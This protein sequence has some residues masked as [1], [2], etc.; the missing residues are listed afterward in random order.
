[1]DCCCEKITGS[2]S[3]FCKETVTAFCFCRAVSTMFMPRYVSIII[4]KHKVF[5]ILAQIRVG[6]NEF[7]WI[8]SN[9]CVEHAG[10]ELLV[11][12]TRDVEPMLGWRWPIVYDAGLTSTQHWFNVSCLASENFLSK[13]RLQ[14]RDLVFWT[15]ITPTQEQFFFLLGNFPCGKKLDWRNIKRTCNR[16]DIYVFII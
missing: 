8:K 1:M 2:N 15:N 7:S 13:H 10:W 12:Q 6:N 9:R 11:Q 5:F 4:Q 16:M 14:P 3:L